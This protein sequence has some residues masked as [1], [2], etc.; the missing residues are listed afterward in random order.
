MSMAYLSILVQLFNSVLPAVCQ[1]PA[2]DR[3]IVCL[4]TVP[5]CFVYVVKAVVVAEHSMPSSP[6][7]TTH[8]NNDLE[9]AHA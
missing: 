1:R 7:S 4:N 8:Q 2:S 5:I 3:H 6:P 9:Q